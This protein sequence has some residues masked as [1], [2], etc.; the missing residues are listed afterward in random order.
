MA[1]TLY[2]FPGNFRAFKALIAAEYNGLEVET[3]DFDAAAAALSP[4]G[5]APVLQTPAGVV[6]ESNAIARYLAKARRDTELSGSSFLEQAQV[7]SWV[8]FS[9]HEIELP[10]SVWTY[11][12]LGYMEFNLAAY[13]KAQV[14]LAAGLKK[15]NDFLLT[16]TY[17]VGEKVSERAK[18]ASEQ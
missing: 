15:L 5:K 10:A 7:D 9:A 6:F 1:L 18:R 3:A 2:T 16:R 12:V 17:L 11:P 13:N 14:D 4:L 8:D